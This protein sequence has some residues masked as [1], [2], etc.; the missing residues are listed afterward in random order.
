MEMRFKST[1]DALP[2]SHFFL[3][4]PFTIQM[5]KQER[6]VKEEAEGEKKSMEAAILNS[7]L[8]AV[9]MR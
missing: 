1:Q 5:S 4:L 7:C 6:R 2:S 9:P 3:A 8:V